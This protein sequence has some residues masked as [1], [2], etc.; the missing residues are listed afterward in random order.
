MLRWGIIGLGGAGMGH[1]RRL[2]RIQGMELVAGCDPVA[3]AR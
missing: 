3:V 2:A 1:A